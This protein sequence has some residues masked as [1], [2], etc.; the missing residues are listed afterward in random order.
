M[1]M[2]SEP[3]TGYLF[4]K[5]LVFTFGFFGVG[6]SALLLV[7][8]YDAIAKYSDAMKWLMFISFAI[9]IVLILLYIA[10][11]IYFAAERRAYENE[12]LKQNNLLY[13]PKQPRKGREKDKPIIHWNKQPDEDFI[14]DKD[15][16]TYDVYQ[17]MISSDTFSLNQ[18][19]LELYGI[20]GGEYNKKIRTSL[21]KFGINI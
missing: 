15:Q 8:F 2:Q 16:E 6:M 12:I 3:S 4:A 21:S 7:L 11:N 20:K 17:E 13:L 5:A 14:S 9:F 19:A 1:A 10:L 18:M